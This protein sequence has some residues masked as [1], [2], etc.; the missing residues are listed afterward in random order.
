MAHG[1]G[2]VTFAELGARI[3]QHDAEAELLRSLVRDRLDEL[4]PDAKPVPGPG[5][6]PT[7]PKGPA[8]TFTLSKSSR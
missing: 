3:Q 5:A 1:N 7:T 2:A 6:S 4:E 8:R